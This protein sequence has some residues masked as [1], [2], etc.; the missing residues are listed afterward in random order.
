MYPLSIME[1]YICF[2]PKKKVVFTCLC[3][4]KSVRTWVQALCHNSDHVACYI[5][6]NEVCECVSICS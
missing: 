4:V 6:I 3:G 1:V 5:M 2:I